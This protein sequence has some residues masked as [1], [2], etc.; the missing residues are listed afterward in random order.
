[1]NFGGMVLGGLK[2]MKRDSLLGIFQELLKK[3]WKGLKA[4]QRVQKN[5]Q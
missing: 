1:M 5:L 2:T 3:H 4:T